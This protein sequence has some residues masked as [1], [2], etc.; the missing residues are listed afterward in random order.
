MPYW[1]EKLMELIGNKETSNSRKQKKLTTE[2]GRNLI[3]SQLYLVVRQP[4]SANY[5]NTRSMK[6]RV[7]E[8]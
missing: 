2:S 6:G 5:T 1:N 8:H 4:K 3:T 7:K